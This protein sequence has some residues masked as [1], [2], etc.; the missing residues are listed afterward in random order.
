[1]GMPGSD[2]EKLDAF[3]EQLKDGIDGPLQDQGP[4]AGEKNKL[5]LL[6]LLVQT[7]IF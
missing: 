2:I 3:A 7:Y 4:S 6:A 1:M 5:S